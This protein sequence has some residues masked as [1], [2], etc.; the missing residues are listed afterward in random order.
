MRT[1]MKAR[2]SPVPCCPGPSSSWPY[3]RESVVCDALGHENTPSSNCF[4]LISWQVISMRYPPDWHSSGDGHHERPCR[5]PGR[6]SHRDR[7][8][9]HV[10]VCGRSEHVFVRGAVRACVRACDR[11]R[12]RSFAGNMH[13]RALRVR[14]FVERT[15]QCTPTSEE[16]PGTTMCW[17]ACAC[18]HE[19][20]GAA[21]ARG[22][23]PPSRPRCP[24]A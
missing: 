2:C 3:V 22:P 21:A 19:C 24:W 20:E 1:G 4:T 11:W 5:P 10:I 17:C 7:V 18:G 6:W 12:A 13:A 23:G 16:G 8:R 9:P 14:T 15:C